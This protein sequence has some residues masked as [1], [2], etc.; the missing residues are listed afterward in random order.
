VETPAL[1]VAGTTGG[2]NGLSPPELGE[3]GTTVLLASPYQILARLGAEALRAQG[4][5]PRLV[6]W[7]GALTRDS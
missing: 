6:G 5:L 7:A 4:G 1:I 3:L 2:T